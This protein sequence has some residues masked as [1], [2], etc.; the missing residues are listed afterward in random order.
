MT[1]YLIKRRLFEN[2]FLKFNANPAAEFVLCYKL[3][4]L[5]YISPHIRAIIR[6][7]PRLIADFV[8]SSLSVPSFLSTVANLELDIGRR[9]RGNRRGRHCP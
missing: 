8:F 4:T 5:S 6:T 7:C 1:S 3:H 9:D 2:L